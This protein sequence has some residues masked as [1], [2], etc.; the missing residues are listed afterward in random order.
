MAQNI[1]RTK[2]ARR[3]A[4]AK[5]LATMAC[6]GLSALEG[7]TGAALEHLQNCIC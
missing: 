5:L 4:A 3:L 1:R 7:V 6:D 2:R